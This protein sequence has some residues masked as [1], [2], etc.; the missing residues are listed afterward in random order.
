MIFNDLLKAF[1]NLLQL[2]IN[3]YIIIILVRAIISWAGQELQNRIFFF[4]KKITDPVFR[5]VHK[6]F[7]FTIIG[8]IDI[9]PLL[10]IFLLYFV[11]N[12]LSRWLIYIV[13]KGG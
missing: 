5:F 2:I 11:N 12:L 8:N 1:I 4:L 10:I 13:V 3:V 9:S 7:P 6:Y